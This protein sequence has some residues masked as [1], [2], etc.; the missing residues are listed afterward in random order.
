MFMP[1]SRNWEEMKYEAAGCWP[2]PVNKGDEFALV[3]KMPASTI[4]AVGLAP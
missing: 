4:K 1:S 2:L 3:T